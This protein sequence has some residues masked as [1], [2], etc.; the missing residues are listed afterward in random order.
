LKVFNWKISVPTFNPS[1]EKKEPDEKI[2]NISGIDILIVRKNIKNINFSVSGSDASVRVSVPKNISEDELRSI[3]QSRLAWICKKVQTA[4]LLPVSTEK[5][6]LT[7]ETHYYFGNA[8]T[9]EVIEHTST[10]K[11]EIQNPGILKIFVQPE[12][13]IATKE[14]LLN[15]FY[16]AELKKRIP[17]LLEKWQS[18]MGLE[19]SEWYVKKMRTRWGTCNINKNRI[20]LSLELAKQP[21]ESLEYVVVHEMTHLLEADHNAKFKKYLDEFIPTWREIEKQLNTSPKR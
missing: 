13:P 14:K 21:E 19:V 9:L 2:I 18:I 11:I 17:P 5:E 20:W 4:R 1:S 6:Y 3:L 12:T 8:Y 10:P 15:E 7:G 16:R